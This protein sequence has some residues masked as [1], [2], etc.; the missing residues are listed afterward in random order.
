MNRIFDFEALEFW[1]YED[2]TTRTRYVRHRYPCRRNSNAIE[3]HLY[4]QKGSKF[5][6]TRAWNRDVQNRFSIIRGNKCF[7]HGI[8]IHHINNTPNDGICAVGRKR[9]KNQ[10]RILQVNWGARCCQI[11]NENNRRHFLYPV[12]F[13]HHIQ[14]RRP[15]PN[16]QFFISFSK[17]SSV[18][19]ISD[20]S[21]K[22]LNFV[23]RT[24]SSANHYRKFKQIFC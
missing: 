24:N 21:G 7:L 10:L 17:S 8:T 4:A 14:F 20:L 3:V 15:R 13:V 18:Q 16:C 23:S 5:K 2:F 19:H 6:A 22:A 11:I 9:F 1:V 12:S